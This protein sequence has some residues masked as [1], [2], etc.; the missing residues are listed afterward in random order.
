MTRLAEELKSRYRDRVIIYD[1]PPLLSSPDAMAFLPQVEAV[2][3]VIAEG[4]TKKR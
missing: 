4:M 3:L 1:L 2:L